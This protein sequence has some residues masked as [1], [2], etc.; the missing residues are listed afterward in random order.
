MSNAR[1]QASQPIVFPDGTMQY[2][3][4]NFMLTVDGFIVGAATTSVWGGVSGT[5]SNQTDL[6][7]ALN[8]KLT[9]TDVNSLVKL[10]A[11]I[12]DATL[13][14]S[15]DSRPPLDHDANKVTTGTFADARISE[16]S[17]TQHQA[18]LSI[19]ESQISD[20]I[21][22]MPFRDDTSTT[23]TLVIGDADLVV[24][25]TGA[26]PAITIPVEASVA[27][28]VGTVLGIRQAGTGTLVLTTTGLTINGSLPSWAQH[29]EINL[30]KVGSDE[31]DVV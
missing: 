29:I 21:H 5:L 24:R 26:S 2:P 28:P 17:V 3:F 20:L 6:Q 31:W 7:S 25:Y 1:L 19:T 10:N 13:D 14:D 22:V 30:R 15:G 4:R 8:L 27:F 11:L 18:A 23:Y 12:A 16:A 9:I